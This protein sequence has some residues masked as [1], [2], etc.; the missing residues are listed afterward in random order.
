MD[1]KKLVGERLRMVRQA[2]GLSLRT[3]AEKL[4]ISAQAISKYE[5][6]A[7][8]PGSTILLSMAKLFGVRIDYFCRINQ[9][10]MTD[11]PEFRAKNAFR[12]KEQTT[13]QAKIQDWL[14]RYEQAEALFPKE[15]P[16]VSPLF[17]T[18]AEIGSDEEIEALALKVRKAWELGTA[19]IPPMG[20]IPLLENHGVRVYLVDAPDSFD[21]VKFKANGYP[22][23]VAQKNVPGDRIRF[24]IAHELGHFLIRTP[25]AGT[26]RDRERPAMRFAGAFLVPA[27][28]VRQELG[29]TRSQ[30]TIEELGLLKAKYGLSMSGWLF[31]AKVLGIIKEFQAVRYFRMFQKLG[32]RQKEPGEQYPPEESPRLERLVMRAHSESLISESKA[33]ELLSMTI[34]QLRKDRICIDE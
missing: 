26:K 32:F 25:K 24:D 34:N 18:P 23:I 17:E 16:K 22:V 28:V 10:V 1:K 15:R 4:E 12:I 29:P 27:Q 8:M 31:R 33:A 3:L 9:V 14:E 2:H 7:D 20:L 19:P 5:R 30:I 11:G 6:G 13:L 21:A